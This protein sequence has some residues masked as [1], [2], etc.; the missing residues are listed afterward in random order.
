M[1][2][3]TGAYRLEEAPAGP[4]TLRVEKDGMRAKLVSGLYVSAGATVAPGR[5][6]VGASTATDR[7]RAGRDR[8]RSRADTRR[9]DGEAASFPAT[10]PPSPG[11][12]KGD[13]VL[14]VDG[15]SVEGMSMADVL[16]R[17][18]GEPGT[19]VGVS[20]QRPDSGQLIDAIIVRARVVH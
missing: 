5:D 2:D 8:R 20:V 14:R 10:R 15:D 11:Y 4:F 18:R 3:D 16:A 9:L 19:T 12:A 1:T 17:V 7:P 13:R 6:P